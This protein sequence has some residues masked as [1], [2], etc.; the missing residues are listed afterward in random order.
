MVVFLYLAPCL[1]ALGLA[2]FVPGE[3]LSAIQWAGTLVAFGGIVVAFADGL[4]GGGAG[5]VLGDLC[6]VLARDVLGVDHGRDPRDAAGAGLGDEDPRL[7]ARA[8][9]RGAAAD[10]ARARRARRRA[11]DAARG[12]QPRL[13]GRDRRVR[14]LSHLVLAAHPVSRGPARGV[15]L[16]DA[17]GRRRVRRDAARGARCRRCSG[18]ARCSSARGSCWSTRRGRRRSGRGLDI[19][20]GQ[21][22]DLA[23]D[24]RPERIAAH[25][26][27]R[28]E[29]HGQ[30]ARLAPQQQRAEARQAV[31][32]RCR[33]GCRRPGRPAGTAAPRGRA[34]RVRRPGQ[35]GL[36]RF[37]AAGP[38]PAGTAR[39][40]ASSG[41]AFDT[42][43]RV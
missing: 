29:R 1:T 2:L 39:C 41:D 21:R 38:A 13:P 8:V 14:Q 3:R 43:S 34:R 12:R 30:G 16:P 6:G 23:F 36:D 33:A 22:L 19:G 5:T 4:L 35:P 37:D 27:Q 31:A 25:A 7:P 28:T 9:G 42:S 32:G 20:R 24:D 17:A 15:R 26:R 40:R 11:A 10:L 18:S